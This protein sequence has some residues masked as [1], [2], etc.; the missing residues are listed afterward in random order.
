MLKIRAAG[1]A[2]AASS[3]AI[4]VAQVSQPAVSPTSQSAALE[5]S[6]ELRVVKPAIQQVGKP[7]LQRLHR[8]SGFSEL[9]AAL[10]KSGQ[11]E[12]DIRGASQ[13][14]SGDVCDIQEH[15]D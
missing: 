6:K 10:G 11:D 12:I 9:D 7:A 8:L 1:K 2:R 3:S 14:T 15:S 13:L 5:N 4:P